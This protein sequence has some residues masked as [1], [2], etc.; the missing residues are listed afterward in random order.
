[1]TNGAGGHRG[2]RWRWVGLAVV[3]FSVGGAAG[4]AA[5][6]VFSP[7]RDVLNETSFTTVEV[8][9]GEV[10]SSLSLNTAAAWTPVPVGVN[11][12]VGT[13][14]TVQVAPGQEVG[15][16]AVLYTVNLRPVVIA[17]GAIPAFR[18]LARDVN[19]ADTG[20]LQSM[21]ASLGFY[22]RAVDGKFELT[23]EQAVKAW[24]KSLGIESN[25]V[26]EVADIVF[27]PAL[28]TRVTFDTSA[29]ARGTALSGGDAV[30][31]GLPAAPE[32]VLPVNDVQSALM[33]D[34]TRVKIAGPEGQSWMGYV[35]G[36]ERDA[37]AGT[38][39]VRLAGKD[40]AVICADECGA[41]PVTGQSLLPS[42]IITVETVTGLVVP[43]AALVTPANGSV[44]LVDEAGVEH[45]VEVTA[46]ADGMSVI[47][48]V[49]A[50]LLVRLPGSEDQAQ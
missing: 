22:T 47:E 3:I 33:P 12:A 16:G 4:W 9:N 14:T 37:D 26:V 31:S 15:Q 35:A 1:M 49:E 27:V 46:S 20:Q 23:T 32:F 41:I 7:P 44:V 19:G 50:G 24:Q 2:S 6:V 11:Q 25:G 5:G 48:G 39:D 18:T 43:S 40:G 13:V 38:V 30:I 8:T 45:S 36:R 17:Q 42:S 21:L 29:V 28:P 10:G 34:G